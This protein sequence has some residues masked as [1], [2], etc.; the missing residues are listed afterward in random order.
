MAQVQLT[1]AGVANI[2]DSAAGTNGLIGPEPTCPIG[3]RQ[4]SPGLSTWQLAE[5]QGNEWERAGCVQAK[6]Q[7]GTPSLALHPLG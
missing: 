6:A 5:V 3:L 1:V 4:A 2:S 7:G